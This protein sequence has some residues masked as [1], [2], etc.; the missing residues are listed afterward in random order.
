M[1]DNIID[2]ATAEEVAA[3]AVKVPSEASSSNKLADKAWVNVVVGALRNGRFVKVEELPDEGEEM[4]IY[5][6]PRESEETGNVYDEYIWMDDE[7]EK[8]GSTDID[9]DNYYTKTAA[10]AKFV[11]KITGRG[12]SQENYTTEEKTKLGGVETGAKDNVVEAASSSVFPSS[13]TTGK[14]YV[15]KD[16][17]KTYRWNGTAYVEVGGGSGSGGAVQSVNGKT[18]A[19]QLDASDVGAVPTTGGMMTGNL[20]TNN[21]YIYLEG[22]IEGAEARRSW[23]AFFG[24]SI[25]DINKKT[26]TVIRDDRIFRYDEADED[27]ITILLPSTSG[28][29]ALLQNLAPDFSA[30]ATYA[31]GQLCVYSNALYRCTTA[32][33]T[34]E[35]WTAAHWTEATVDDVLAAIRSAL[36]G[37]APLDSPA[38]TGTP[39]APN[40][41]AQSADGQVANKKYVD[42]KVA[43]ATPN[44]D[45]VMRVDPETGNIYYT[46]PDTQS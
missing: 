43:G 34:T 39:T 11:E 15:A 37:K 5:L 1:A 46:T 41:D 27:E 36:D 31:V 21:N 23:I 45:Y 30:S 44:L 16:T 32:I 12:L 40:M 22:A 18:G 17:N 19:V 6:V 8:I 13:G 3:I 29:L 7:W 26:F 10:D 2:L 4:T 42:D 20:S 24:L 33:E 35:A 14:I 28:T 25:S 9:L 38:F